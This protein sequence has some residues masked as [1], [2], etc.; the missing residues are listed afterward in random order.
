MRAF[1]NVTLSLHLP[2]AFVNAS[3][4]VSTRL[5]KQ[6]VQK[7]FLHSLRPH[8]SFSRWEKAGMRASPVLH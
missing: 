1:T 2:G 8:R 3:S 4:A 5:K 6:Q 7:I